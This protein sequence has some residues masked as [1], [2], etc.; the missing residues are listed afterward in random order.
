MV[1]KW[2]RPAL[3]AVAVVGACLAASSPAVAL[4]L[5]PANTQFDYQIGGAY[6]PLSEVS[7]VDRDRSASPV[8]GKYNI[9]YVN[10]F[11]TQPEEAEWWTERHPELLL[12]NSR[13]EIVI[14][15]AWNEMLLDIRTAAKRTAI[16]EIVGGWIDGCRTS[17]FNAVE[18]DN[19]ESWTRSQG[20]LTEAQAIAY[21]TLLATR[22]HSDELAIAQ[23]NTSELGTIGKRTIGF[24][25]A[26]AEECNLWRE[27]PE[28]QE[29]FGTQVYEIEYT[30]GGGLRNY[31]AACTNFGAR[32]SIIYR[33]RN[34]VARGAAGYTYRWC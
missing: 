2:L 19:L 18:P 1:A 17:G 28:Y 21:A 16:A 6:T 24:D 13:G 23:K 8:V 11:Q 4:T 27:C 5:P 20:L 22:A 12:R 31:E 3:L 14:D 26:I 32:I 30:D 10:A 34:V 25:F 15:S 29:V 9:C 7:I 33:D